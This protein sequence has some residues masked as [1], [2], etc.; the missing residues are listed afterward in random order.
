MLKPVTFIIIL[1]LSAFTFFNCT[2]DPYVAM[3]S[4]NPS[5]ILSGDSSAISFL[6]LGDSY[7]IG[8]SVDEHQRF[9]YHTIEWLKKMNVSTYRLQYIATTGWTTSS[10][11]AAIESAK[12][13]QPYDV[14]TLLIGVNDQY[15]QF[16]TAGY[17][18]RFTQLLEKSI[19]LAGF[20]SSRVFVLSIP[21]YSATPYVPA[22]SK[23]KVSREI[24]LYN[25]INKEIAEQYDCNYINITES[26]REAASDRSLVA[27]DNLHPSGREYK[28]WADMLGPVI[29]KVLK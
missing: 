21:D 9:P 10:L 24:D 12:L 6:A 1:A 28:K 22:A 3:P 13:H 29:L 17:R 23:Q 20:T 18:I 5:S 4:N 8:Q 27:N 25:G 2:K 19:S 14:V 16:D 26:S 11:Q 15:R 7:T